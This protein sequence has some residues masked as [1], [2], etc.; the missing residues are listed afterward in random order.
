VKRSP[1]RLVLAAIHAV[2]SGSALL[3]LAS[4]WLATAYSELM[5]DAAGKASV[6]RGIL[7]GILGLVPAL[8]VAGATGRLLAGKRPAGLA[9][10]KL[11]RMKLVGANGVLVLVPCAVWLAHLAAAP[12]LGRLFYGL[13]ALELCAGVVNLVLLAQNARDGLI[14]AGRVRPRRVARG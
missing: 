11:A 13:Q 10:R 4:F 8:V 7:V 9:A 5:L 14:L 12:P 1:R 2:A 3:L 6:K